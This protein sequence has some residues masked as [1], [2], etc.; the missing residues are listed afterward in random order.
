[1]KRNNVISLC[2]AFF[3]VSSV[4][5]AGSAVYKK[6]CFSLSAMKHYEQCQDYIQS[7]TGKKTA[8]EI[9]DSYSFVKNT[10][11]KT[12]SMAI[13]EENSENFRICTYDRLLHF[14]R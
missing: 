1:M 3:V 13:S 6:A 11:V 2:G 7:D 5:A 10:D 8:Q 12:F 9:L 4:I 14:S